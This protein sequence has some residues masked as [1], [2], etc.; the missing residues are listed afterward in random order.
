MWTPAGQTAVQASQIRQFASCWYE[1]GRQR[2]D[3]VVDGSRQRDAA[4][5]A[6][7]LAPGEDVGRAGGQALPAAD[8]GEHVAVLG[9]EQVQ[10][11]PPASP[12]PVCHRAAAA[13][14]VATA[15]RPATKLRCAAATPAPSSMG[16]PASARAISTAAERPEH[17]ELVEG[18][19]VADPEDLAANP[20]QPDAERQVVPLAGDLHDV[21]GVDAVRGDHGGQAVRDLGSGPRRG[22]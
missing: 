22:S 10:L 20:P 7:G 4:A 12:V 17:F 11:D 1:L 6:L 5:R 21:A 2:Q 18:A 3:A 14:G 16:T 9:A 13:T 19:E 8:A 15:W